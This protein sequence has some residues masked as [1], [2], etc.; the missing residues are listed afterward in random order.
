MTSTKSRVT[1]LASGQGNA[2]ARAAPAQ[3]GAN[4]TNI[5]SRLDYGET[6]VRDWK[7]YRRFKFQ[8]KKQASNATLRDLANKDSHKVWAE[9]DM[10][11]GSESPSETVDKLFEDLEADLESKK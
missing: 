8:V 10:P 4:D 9:A 6:F 1:N 7:E 3:A 2:G 5:G 11:I